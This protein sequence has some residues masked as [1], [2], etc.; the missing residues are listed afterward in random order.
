VSGRL[1]L[2]VELNKLCL[3]E[4]VGFS[5]L[6]QQHTLLVV[7]TMAPNESTTAV[8]KSER[9]AARVVVAA[10]NRDVPMAVAHLLNDDGTTVD[11]PV[12][13]PVMKSTV[14]LAITPRPKTGG[15]QLPTRI[16]RNRMDSIRLKNMAIKEGNLN[17]LSRLNNALC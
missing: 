1:V 4:H 14:S 6:H 8:R 16:N 3:T 10:A 12:N 7:T 5:L 13:Q 11:Q 2:A 15:K 17:E 9:V